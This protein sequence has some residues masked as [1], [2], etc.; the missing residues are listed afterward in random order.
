MATAT[1]T[2]R[3]M[4]QFC[5]FMVADHHFGIEV[6]QVQEVLRNQTLTTVPM[7]P[8]EVAGLLNLRGQILPAIHL[9]TR[10]GFESQD[11]T[12]APNPIHVIINT[13]EGPVDL[14][15][16]KVGDVLSLDASD[17]EETHESIQGK[18]KHIVTGIYKLTDKLLLAID[19]A[20]VAEI[21]N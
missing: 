4:R 12:G 19:P 2:S 18:M 7:A 1:T 14:L 10:F 16:D 5:T 15:A 6:N 21:E 13:S 17:Y 11:G 20:K 8:P 9:R 3:E